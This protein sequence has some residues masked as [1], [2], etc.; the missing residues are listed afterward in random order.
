MDT[1]LKDTFLREYYEVFDADGKPKA[2]GRFKCI[3]LINIC[4]SIDSSLD[5]G[6]SSTGMMNTENIIRL[7]NKLSED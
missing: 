6:N 4:M 3:S 2:C 7:K 1:S 5:Y